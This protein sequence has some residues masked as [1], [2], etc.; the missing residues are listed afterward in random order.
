MNVGDIVRLTHSKEQGVITKVL[1]NDLFEVEID[2][3]F[4]LPIL[5]KELTFVSS[6]ENKFFT[7]KNGIILPQSPQNLPKA[8]KG[9]FLAF[10][11]VND[12]ELAIYLINNTDW[13]ICFILSLG[14]DKNHRG[15]LAGLLHVRQFLK[16]SHQISLKSLDEYETFS[17]KGLYFINGYFK[18]KPPFEKKIRI[19][20]SELSF[21][22]KTAP[23]LEK[24]MYLFQLDTEDKTLSI[25]PSELKEKLLEKKNVEEIKQKQFQTPLSVVDLHIEK[26]ASNYEVLNN[27]EILDLQIKTFESNLEYAIASGLDE[28]TFIHGVGNGVLKNQIQKYLSK[29]KNVAWFEDA[30]KQ[31]F[32]YGATK[33]K[34]K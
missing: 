27:S 29:H 13:E 32:G 9:I 19:K 14:S 33:V 1:K 16:S 24:E 3:G 34:I 26:I 15:I 22:K 25:N 5:R 7:N 4:R 12:K 6:S 2:G 8:E 23:I 21:T 11:N 20:N 31:K 18:D 28:I 30:Q 17:F 10:E